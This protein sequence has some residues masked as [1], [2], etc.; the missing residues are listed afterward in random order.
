MENSLKKIAIVGISGSGKSTFSRKL[1]EKTGL[2]LFHMDQL[3]WKAN[4]QAVSED[5]YLKEHELLVQKPEWI[6]EGY[7]DVKMATRLKNADLV[8]WLD[9]SG[10]RCAWHLII[11][12]LKY[13]KKS[14]PELP[15]E[16]IER[17]KWSFFKM[18]L[19]G[20]ERKDIEDA[21][22]TSKPMNLKRFRSPRELKS[23]LSAYKN[24]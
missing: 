5:E 3:Y 13:H 8:L 10:L 23:F 4:W 21:I 16:A 2:P 9:Y 12:R 11:R 20:G 19:M 7:V 15:R 22:E 1:A 17:L 6:V 18:V 14:R 24:I